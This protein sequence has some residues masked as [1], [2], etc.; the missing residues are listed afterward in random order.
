[1]KFQVKWEQGHILQAPPPP[2]QLL[3]Q[4]MTMVIL[5]IPVDLGEK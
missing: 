2:I 4:V 5:G 1:M 3:Q